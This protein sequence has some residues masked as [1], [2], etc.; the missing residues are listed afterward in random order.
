MNDDLEQK[1]WEL[2]YG[3]LSDDEASALRE[4]IAAEPERQIEGRRDD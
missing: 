1:L 4:R 2:E 3:L